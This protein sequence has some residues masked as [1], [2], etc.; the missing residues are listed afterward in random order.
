MVTSNPITEALRKHTE[1]VATLSDGIINPGCEDRWMLFEDRINAVHAAAR[2]LVEACARTVHKMARMNS[3]YE[4]AIRAA[5]ENPD[6]E[7]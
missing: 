1:A 5:L 2:E 4:D 7:R 3:A 6:A